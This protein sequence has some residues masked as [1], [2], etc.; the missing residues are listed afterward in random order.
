LNSAPS[1]DTASEQVSFIND[2]DVANPPV[3]VELIQALNDDQ[4]ATLMVTAG[5]MGLGDVV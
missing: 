4:I 5:S 3:R 1:T 2:L